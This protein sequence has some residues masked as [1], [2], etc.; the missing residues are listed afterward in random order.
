MTRHVE[1]I[2]LSDM[3][4]GE[5]HRFSPPKT[6]SGG[7]ASERGFPNLAES[8]VKDLRD[9]A[10]DFLQPTIVNGTSDAPSHFGMTRVLCLSGDFTKTGKDTE[11]AEAIDFVEQFKK[12]SPEGLGFKPEDIFVCPGNHDLDW[13]GATDKLRWA[14]YTTFLNE[15]YPKKKFAPQGNDLFGSVIVSETA[16]IVVLSLNSEMEV[17]NLDINKTRGDLNTN[18][19]EWAGKELE[20]IPKKKLKE[21]IKVA[22]VHHH[23]ILLPTLAESERGY[24]AIHGAQHLLSLLHKYGF[25][26]LLHGHKHYPHTFHESVKNAFERTDEHA[27]VI[28]AGGSCG[29]EHLALPSQEGATQTYNRI[30]IHWDA[31]QGSTRVQV[32]T[33]GLNRF[34]TKTRKEL[35][36][37]KWSWRTIAIDD[38]TSLL[39]RRSSLVSPFAL[40]Y[41]PSKPHGDREHVPR[42]N[43]YARTRGNF[44]VAEVKPS[45]IPNQTNEVNLRIVQHPNEDKAAHIP[46]SVTWSA[47]PKFD[48]IY[49]EREEDPEFN[50]IYAYYGSAL[51]R[52]ELEFG[53][54]YKC[55]VYIYAP[56]LPKKSSDPKPKRT[57]RGKTHR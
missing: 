25:H 4:F 6:T 2:H 18:Q 45:L 32:E 44:P 38:R 31:D 7:K 40:R 26:V 23:P 20:N 42:Q 49:V 52:A 27:L 13:N 47:G 16:G 19:L 9:P 17:R 54:G 12:P 48:R 21:F 46:K 53:D 35:L 24:D 33:R 57:K 29:C 3:H 50:A 1:L 36:P 34:E 10:T 30:R 8:L 37:S 11:F 56:M 43:E 55:D 28:V 14:R 51:M 5:G 15:I 22:M 41:T 39:G